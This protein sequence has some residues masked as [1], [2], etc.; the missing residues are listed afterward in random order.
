MARA[1]SRYVCQTCGGAFLRWEGQC[2]SC[3][4]WNTLVETLVRPTQERSSPKARA[5]AAAGVAASASLA[6]IREGG[7]AER[8]PVGIGEVDRVLGGGIVGGSLILLGGEPGIGKS[9]LLLQVAGAVGIALTGTSTDGGHRSRSESVLYASAEESPGQVRIRAARL[10][11][12]D[13]RAGSAIRV[14]GETDV[15]RIVELA[16]TER[17]GLLVVDS[18][19]TVSAEELDGPPGSVGQVREVATRLVELAKAEGIPTVLVGHVTK[20]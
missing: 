7:D 14:V 8:R 19:Q 13:G 5:A 20:A 9:T 6:D 11:L 1:Q 15:G 10:G 3:G 2:R 4:G 12:V 18:V 17:P 16:R